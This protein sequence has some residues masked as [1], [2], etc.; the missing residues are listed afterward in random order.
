MKRL[1][2]KIAKEFDVSPEQEGLFLKG[3]WTMFGIYAGIIIV[4]AYLLANS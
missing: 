4:T 3:F 1:N 2:A